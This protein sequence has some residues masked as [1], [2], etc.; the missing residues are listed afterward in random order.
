MAEE[1]ILEELK[2]LEE[3][4][5]EELELETQPDFPGKDG[6]DETSGKISTKGAPTLADSVPEEFKEELN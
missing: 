3:E 6:P 2:R 5:Q 1:D 4:G